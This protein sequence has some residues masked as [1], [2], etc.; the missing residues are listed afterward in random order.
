MGCA[1]YRLQGSDG[2]RVG[3]SRDDARIRAEPFDAIEPEL[4]AWVA[5]PAAIG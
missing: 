1:E 5:I 3:V 4:T 2:L